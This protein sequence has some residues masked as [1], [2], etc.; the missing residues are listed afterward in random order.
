MSAFATRWLYDATSLHLRPTTPGSTLCRS[1]NSKDLTVT[2]GL[3]T[4]V[5]EPRILY[6]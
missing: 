2:V 1:L 6:L 5:P 4:V 3:A